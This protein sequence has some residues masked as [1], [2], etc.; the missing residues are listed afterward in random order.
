MKHKIMPLIII[1]VLVGAVGEGYWYF[2]QNPDE[3][4]R[5]QVRFGLISEAEVS[6]EHSASGFIETEEVGIAAETKGRITSVAVDEGDFV[7]AGQVLVEIDITLLDAEAAQVEAEVET[8]K[9][10]LAKAKAGV[11]VE[12]IARAEAA[13]TMAEANAEAAYTLWQN[14]IMLRDNPQELGLQIDAARTALDLAELQIAYAIP[15]KDAGETLW[16]L[17]QRQWV[18]IQDGLSVHIPR[19]RTFHMD[20]PEGA[21]QDAG[22]AWNLAGTDMWAAWVDLNN[23]IARRDEAE[24]AVNDLLRIRDDPQEAQ[25]KVEEAKAAYQTALVEVETAKARVEVLEAGSRPEEIALVQAQVELAEA[26]LAALNVQRDK[27]TLVAPVAG[28]VVKRMIHEGE[29][30]IPGAA[31]LMLADLTEVTLTVYVPEPD[32]DAVSIGQE[33]DVFVDTFPGESFTGHLTFVNDEAEFTPKNVQTR[34]ERINTVFA[35]KIE[36]ENLDQRLKPGMPADAILSRGR[37]L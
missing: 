25:I 24:I 35:V 10:Q 18:D 7:E 14:A 4:L 32:I 28:W 30:A 26:D 27:H 12:E 17:R 34:A 33:V 31:L 8:A 23:A 15:L 20:Y 36:L 6:G 13:V 37:D 19:G 21:K 9:A 5:L 29:M 22:V 1:L 16:E 2:T 3:L 11:R